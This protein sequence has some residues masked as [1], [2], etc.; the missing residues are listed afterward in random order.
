MVAIDTDPGIDDALALALALRSP[1]LSVALV[2][3]VAGNV[4]V[5]RATEN[6]RRVLGVLRPERVPSLA[7]GAARPL[8]RRLETAPW[9]HA[10]D[11]LGG[12]THLRRRDGSPRFPPAPVSVRRDAAARLAALARAR[13]RALTL[14]ALGPLT[15]VARALERDPEAL[16][17]V[18]RVVVMG[19]AVSV[20]GNV[21]PAAEFNF[22]VDPEAAAAVLGA[23]LPLTLVPLDVTRR[24]LL[25]ASRLREALGGARTPWAAAVRAMTHRLV[26]GR[27]HPGGIP[28]HDPLAV[29]A[30]VDP[31]LLGCIRL[32]LAVETQGEHTRGMSLADR[33]APARPEFAAPRVEVATEVDAE[34]ALALFAERVL[35]PEAG[36]RPARAGAGVVVVGSANTDLIVTAGHLPAP[37]ETVVG[38]DLVRSFGGKGANQAVAARRAGARVDLIAC[39]GRDAHGDAYLAHL[40]EQGVGSDALARDGRA[41]SGVALIT[42]DRRGRNLITVAPG[43]N[44]RLGPGELAALPRLLRAAG[45]LAAQLEIPLGTVEAAFRLAR[46]AGVITLLNPAPARRLPARLVRLTDVLVANEGEARILGAEAAGTPALA[47]AAARALRERGHTAVVITLGRGGVAWA[48]AEGCGHLP[49]HA[50]R[51]RDT[52][53]A[54]DAFVGYLACALAEGRAP[55]RAVALANAAAALAVTRVGA[56][57][58]LPARG[59]VERLVRRCTR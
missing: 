30:A 50:V 42:V 11:G 51:V 46:K 53:G 39:L 27:E 58:A 33:R 55:A 21:T 14:I 8:R 59:A 3:T 17:G 49:A 32:P 40:R 20:P 41:P 57:S 45:A 15:N 7:Q 13:R 48:D 2:S 4:G 52:T 10:D 12:L 23:G 44:A 29:A 19:G 22:H 43:A 25:T 1:E 31:S 28:L 37:G 54:G 16:R 9:V 34:R 26:G 6:A 36:K 35:A 5:A 56:Q 24:V 18:G 47:Q 38:K